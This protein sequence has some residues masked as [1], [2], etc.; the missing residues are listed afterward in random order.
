M[1]TIK[2]LSI[3][4]C[5]LMSLV[6]STALSACG[7]I[8]DGNQENTR[9]PSNTQ[10]PAN[11]A[12]QTPPDDIAQP[13]TDFDWESTVGG[14]EITNYKGTSKD[15]V[16]PAVIENKQ[17]TKI[18]SSTFSGNVMIESV[19]LPEGVTQIYKSTFM[20]C[21][22]LKYLKCLGFTGEDGIKTNEILI[23]LLGL[24]SLSEID[25]P[26]AKI[27]EIADDLCNSL[28]KMNIPSATILLKDKNSGSFDKIESIT[29]PDTGYNYCKV[30]ISDNKTL[31]LYAGF[32]NS[33]ELTIP[34]DAQGEPAPTSSYLYSDEHGIAVHLI[35]ITDENRAQVYCDFFGVNSIT[36][37]GTMYTK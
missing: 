32:P 14:I 5:L 13:L 8:D 6:L 18:A 7:Y 12:T 15:V 23:P 9:P 36:V 20:N 24:K 16:V 34:A 30:Q 2:L 31:G 33:F 37:N 29:I 27:F 25:F 28:V 35:E 1:K 10:T 19:V 26:N 22:N 17:V 11:N 3:V 21:D 4:L